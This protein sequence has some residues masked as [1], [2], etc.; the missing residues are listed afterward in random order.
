MDCAIAAAAGAFINSL[1][2][3]NPYFGGWFV[4]FFALVVVW[5]GLFDILKIVMSIFILITVLGVLYAAIHVFPCA[6]AMM[7][8]LS[9]QVPQVPQWAIAE[10]IGDKPWK[11]I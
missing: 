3:I 1:V 4:A 8:N 2:P 5:S 7:Q 6:A 9:F 11:L 10:G